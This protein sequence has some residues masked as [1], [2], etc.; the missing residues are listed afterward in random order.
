[1]SRYNIIRLTRASSTQRGRTLSFIM[2]K[3]TVYSHLRHHAQTASKADPWLS[4]NRERQQS[5][6]T[7]GDEQGLAR[8]LSLVLGLNLRQ[9]RRLPLCSTYRPTFALTYWFFKSPSTNSSQSHGIA[10]EF[11]IIQATLSPDLLS[12]IDNLLNS[13]VPTYPS[14]WIVAKFRR[15]YPAC[16]HLE[17]DTISSSDYH[18]CK[19]SL[20]DF[21]LGLIGSVSPRHSSFPIFKSISSW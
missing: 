1:M 13:T 19:H 8:T 2:G 9:L 10:S 5:F 3:S 12:E 21:N 11:A 17:Y 20:I 16:K 4:S 6:Y 7:S 15:S 14:Q 18:D